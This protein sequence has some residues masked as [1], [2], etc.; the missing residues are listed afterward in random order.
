MELYQLVLMEYKYPNR[1]SAVE[2]VPTG[3]AGVAGH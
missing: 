2:L 3:V 1:A